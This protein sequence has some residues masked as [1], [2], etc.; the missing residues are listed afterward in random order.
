MSAARDP[1]LF[2]VFGDLPAGALEGWAPVVV[3]RRSGGAGDLQAVGGDGLVELE[4][5]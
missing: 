3:G 4:A 1:S 2:G 5:A